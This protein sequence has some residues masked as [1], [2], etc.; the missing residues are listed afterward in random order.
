MKVLLYSS[1]ILPNASLLDQY[2]IKLDL[3]NELNDTNAY[4]MTVPDN[5]KIIDASS[6]IEGIRGNLLLNENNEP[7]INMSLST[8]DPMRHP[9]SEYD[10]ISSGNVIVYPVKIPSVEKI[11]MLKQKD[12]EAYSELISLMRNSYNL[13]VS[14]EMVENKETIVSEKTNDVEIE[15]NELNIDYI[16]EDFNH[17]KKCN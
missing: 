17:N 6:C 3:L 10:Y 13:N 2:N 15:Y 8:E 14:D 11:Q 16:P 4:M 1:K 9:D 7:I 5:I 12:E